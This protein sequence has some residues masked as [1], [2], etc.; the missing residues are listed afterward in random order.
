[1]YGMLLACLSLAALLLVDALVSLGVAALRPALAP[2]IARLG[3]ADRARMFFLLRTAPALIALAAVFVLL[4]PSYLIHEPRDTR[5]AVRA[6]LALAAALAL[7]GIACAVRRAGAAWLATRRLV[8]AWEK[9]AGEVLLDGF[10]VC[11]RRIRHRFP[12]IGMVRV[13]RPRLFVA[14]QVLSSLTAEELAAALAHERGHL[15]AGDNLKLAVLCAC[16]DLLSVLP[17]GRDLERRWRA[18]AEEAA[19][20]YAARQGP[21]AALDLA[22]ALVKVARLAPP[23]A[24]AVLAPATVMIAGD[25]GSVSARVTRLAGYRHKPDGARTPH[26]R[27]VPVLVPVAL[28]L[29]AAAFLATCGPE[30]LAAI[31]LASEFLVSL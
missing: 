4:V 23:G 30:L 27:A 8:R 25:P 3:A 31:H 7:A 21:T 28:A 24:S 12:V 11:A 9:D 1:M 17:G 5:E 29:L 2:A 26:G 10:G 15:A 20:D 13:F 14:E 16:R 18:A 19:D 6:G 22:S